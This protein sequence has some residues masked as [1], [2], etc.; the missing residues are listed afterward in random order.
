ML[1]PKKKITKREIK[2]DPLISTFDQATNFYY[3]HKKN[4][5][6]AITALIII[7]VGI[8]VYVNNHRANNEKAAT[9]LGKVFALYDLG[10]TDSRQY[11]IAVNGQPDRGIMG[12]K[13]IVDNYGSTES[14]EL[15]RFYLATA[16][17]NLGQYDDAL[18]NF[19]SFSS[20]SGLLKAAAFAGIGQCYEMKNEYTKAAEY[21]E[22]AAGA[23]STSAVT[24]DYINSAAR[25]YGVAGEKEK[26]IDLL[27]RLKKEFPTSTFARDADRYIS[28]FSA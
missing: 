19:D 1:S 6:Y 9:E 28:Q 21:F 4:I 11:Q 5:S 23:S 17:L 3:E 12:L 15:A 18:K 27:K 10:T 20:G 8:V 25:C 16:Y 14:G 26:A 2:Q 22:R 13:A 7:V 24:P